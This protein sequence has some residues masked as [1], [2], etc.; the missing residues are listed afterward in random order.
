MGVA[1]SSRVLLTFNR[2][3]LG[4][5]V[6]GISRGEPARGL[7]DSAASRPAQR[8]ASPRCIPATR[9]ADDVGVAGKCVGAP[10]HINSNLN[11]SR[12]GSAYTTRLG[13]TSGGTH[14][15]RPVLILKQPAPSS[16]TLPHAAH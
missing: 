12:A 2:G 9:Q 10:R 7:S 13:Q 11:A 16:P 8:P 15:V 5:K 4:P 14:P 1:R 6:G 3:V